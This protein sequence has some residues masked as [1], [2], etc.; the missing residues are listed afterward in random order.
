M[1]QT[2]NFLPCDELLE[3]L[4][5][6][7]APCVQFK[8]ACSGIATW[9]PAAGLIPRGFIGG[10]GR[11]EDI[12]LVLLVAEPGNPQPGESHVITG[13][14]REDLQKICAYVY[15]HYENGTD[16]F[17]RNIRYILNICWPG[18]D[19]YQQLKKTWVTET[20]L[21]SAPVETGPVRRASERVCAATYLD[22]ELRLLEGRTIVALGG[23]SQRRSK[24]LPH[25]ST[26][27]ASVAPPGANF[28]QAR[29]H[30]G[31][32]FLRTLGH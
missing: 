1:Q 9:N 17:H 26:D 23:K 28:L 19:L 31:T 11:L 21:C 25:C 24:G 15:Q 22:P 8:G 32:R 16:L 20:Y 30:R 18:L 4:A 10:F 27:A 13:N 6:A 29:G 12:E 14:A 2:Q 7:Y 3:V 5:P